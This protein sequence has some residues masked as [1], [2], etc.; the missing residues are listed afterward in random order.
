MA[1]R[2]K[3]ITMALMGAGGIFIL[4]V[5]DRTSSTATKISHLLPVIDC[6]TRLAAWRIF[7]IAFRLYSLPV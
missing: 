2:I 3:I 7:E 4:Y 5:L 6:Y 1:E